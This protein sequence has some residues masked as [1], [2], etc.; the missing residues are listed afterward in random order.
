MFARYQTYR[1]T[2]VAVNTGDSDQT[3]P[4]WFPIGDDY[5]E[6]LHGAAL[7]LTGVASLR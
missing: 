6:E 3:V 4:F 1:Y 2:L 7:N 5:A